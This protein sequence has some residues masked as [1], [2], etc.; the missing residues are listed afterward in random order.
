MKTKTTDFR[1]RKIPNDIWADFK[2]MCIKKG[3]WPNDEIVRMI[4]EAVKKAGTT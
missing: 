1:V 3:V 2:I 4:V